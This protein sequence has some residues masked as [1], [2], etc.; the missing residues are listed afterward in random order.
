MKAHPF[1]GTFLEDP[2]DVPSAVVKVLCAQIGIQDPTCLSTYQDNRQ[3][4]AHMAEIRSCFGYLDFSDPRMGF[5]LTRWLYA[6][7]W[8]G[9][10]RPG[11]LFERATSWLLANKVLLP[12]ASVLERFVS[13][14][15]QRVETR[16]WRLG[17]R[18]QPVRRQ[19]FISTLI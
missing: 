12:G 10:E 1:F 6:Q 3:R 9:T 17:T 2:T 13:R 11:A 5:R 4:F 14:L 19:R 18:M 16:V 8:T 15:R 7:C